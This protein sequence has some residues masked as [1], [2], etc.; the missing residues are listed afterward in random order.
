MKNARHLK[1]DAHILNQ[2]AKVMVDSGVIGN[3]M[4]PEFMKK[5][6]LLGKTKVAP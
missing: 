6:G 3:F 2:L 4:H 5:L 1:V